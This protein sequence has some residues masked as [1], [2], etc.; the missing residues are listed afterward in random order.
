ME[1]YEIIRDEILER[2]G[3]GFYTCKPHVITATMDKYVAERM[4]EIYKQNQSQ[5][6]AYSIRT[7]RARE[8]ENL[9][10]CVNCNNYNRCLLHIEEH[11]GDMIRCIRFGDLVEYVRNQR[12]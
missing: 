4:L 12:F 7:I 10:G 1:I 3:N 9:N 2:H 5:N 11:P 8:P 6:E